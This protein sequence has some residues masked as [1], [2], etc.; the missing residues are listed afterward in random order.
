MTLALRGLP[1]PEPV[2][3]PAVQVG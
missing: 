3:W 1:V 2:M